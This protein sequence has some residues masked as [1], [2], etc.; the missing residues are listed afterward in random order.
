MGPGVQ[1]GV[2]TPGGGCSAAVQSTS[3]NQPVNLTP[4]LVSHPMTCAHTRQLRTTYREECDA[5]PEPPA[6]LPS[7]EANTSPIQIPMQSTQKPRRNLQSIPFITPTDTFGCYWVYPSKP[8]TIPDSNCVP[9]DFCDQPHTREVADEPSSKPKL[10]DSIR[11]AIAPCPNLSTYYFLDW[12]W[13]GNNKSKATHGVNLSALDQ[14]LAQATYEQPRTEGL[15]ALDGW[16]AKTVTVPIPL[17]GKGK[18]H[19]PTTVPIEGMFLQAILGGIRKGF[20]RNDVRNFVYK[21]YQS[22]YA[23]PGAPPLSKPQ[24]IMDEIY[25]SPAMLEVHKEVQRLD[26]SDTKC[27]LPRVVGAVMLG[28]DALQLGDFSKNK[29]WVLYMWLGNLSKYERFNQA[30]SLIYTDNKAVGNKEVEALLQPTSLVPTDNAFSRG[31]LPLKFNFYTMFTVDLLHEIELG[32]LLQ[33]L[34]IVPTFCNSTIRKFSNDVAILSRL[35]ARDFEDILQCCIPIFKG[36]LPKPLDTEVQQLLFTFAYWHALAKLRQHTSDSLTKLKNITTQLG[37]KMRALRESTADLEIFETPREFGSRQRR[38][39]AKAQQSGLTNAV[40]VVRKRCELNLNT[41]KF[42]AIGHYVA[43]ICLFGTTDS[44]STQTV[45][46]NFSI[47]RSKDSRTADFAIKFFIP[48]LK[49]H[50]LSRISGTHQPSDTHKFII[51]NE[52]LYAH[53]TLQINYTSYDVRRQQDTINPKS[54]CR[55]IILPADT[56]S[57]A[58]PFLYAKVLGIYH[59]S[60]RFDRRPAKRMNFLWVRW[61]DYDEKEPGG[62]DVCRLDR[63]FY[64]KCRNDLELMNAFG[65]VAPHH[66]IRAAHLIPDFECGTTTPLATLCLATTVRATGITITLVDDEGEE[67]NM[68]E[69]EAETEEIMDLD[70]GCNSGAGN[71]TGGDPNA[72]RG[73]RWGEN[74]C[75]TDGDDT[76]S[77]S[78]LGNESDDGFVEELYDF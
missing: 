15:K 71:T 24:M 28:S 60:V 36:L 55:F 12:F 35:A 19:L 44:Y 52:R 61:L 34:T 76:G 56:S 69:G 42:H 40:Q 73:E 75:D 5:L 8:L 45:I 25:T 29:A 18:V 43:M 7:T 23:P 62:W 33:S 58:H 49:E 37:D 26:I 66:I 14:S 30:R 9:E 64:G 53:A 17:V 46:P 4:N 63:V 41:P 68:N 13:N 51:Q 38:A 22:Y 27:T 50:L 6:P 20:M 11:N 16:S 59:A 31:L 57:S 78:E 77:D 48:L 72:D 10:T 74:D 70:T 3:P 32:M 67:L 21:P 47:G 1:A 54:T 2:D 39:A 65:F